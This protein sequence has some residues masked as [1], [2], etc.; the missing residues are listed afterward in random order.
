MDYVV[1]SLS[2]NGIANGAGSGTVTFLLGVS[3]GNY[4]SALQLQHLVRHVLRMVGR[5]MLLFPDEI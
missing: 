5:L 1:D 4:C 3:T 2:F